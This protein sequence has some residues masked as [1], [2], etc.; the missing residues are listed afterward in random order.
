MVLGRY[1]GPTDPEA[2]STMLARILIENG[3]VIRRNTFCQ[4]KLEEVESPDMIASKAKFM[5]QISERLAPPTDE[6]DLVTI[7]AITLEYELYTKDVEPGLDDEVDYEPDA[8]DEYIAS[9][10]LLLKGH[11]FKLGTVCSR[12]KDINGYPIGKSNENPILDSRIY[13]VEFPDGKVLEYTVNTISLTTAFNSWTDN[14][15]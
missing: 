12:L 4:L 6:E 5:V 15:S 13:E 1:L 8:L 10:D 11:E 14:R 3:Q 7:A 2:G 9:Q